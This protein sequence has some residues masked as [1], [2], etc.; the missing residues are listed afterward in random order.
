MASSQQ[1]KVGKAKSNIIGQ[2]E[3]I[4]EKQKTLNQLAEDD[5]SVR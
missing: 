4:Q 2:Q 1:Q 3:A 5:E